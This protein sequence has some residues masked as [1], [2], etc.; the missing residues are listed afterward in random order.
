MFDGG[1][2]GSAAVALSLIAIVAGPSKS[3]ITTVTHVYPQASEN[4]CFLAEILRFRGRRGGLSSFLKTVC[5]AK[6][7]AEALHAARGVD[8]LLFAGEERVAN[9]A[10]IDVNAGCGAAGGERVPAGTVNRAG[11][12]AGMDLGTHGVTNSFVR[13]CVKA[14]R[15]NVSR[16]GDLYENNP[17]AVCRVGRRLYQGEPVKANREVSYVQ[18]TSVEPVPKLRFA[19]HPA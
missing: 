6:L 4:R 1:P 5:A 14:N 15:C 11:L 12:V 9:A 3:C 17:L 8:E 13:A 19:P 10:N 16:A 2:S 7:L 18:L